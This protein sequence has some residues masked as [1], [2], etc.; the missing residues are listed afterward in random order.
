MKRIAIFSII[1]NT[2][3]LLVSCS[4]QRN[5]TLTYIKYGDYKVVIR[6]LELINSGIHNIDI[7][8]ADIQDD[9]FPATE[10]FQCFLR[11]YDFVGLEATWR[12]A[13]VIDIHFD[14]GVVSSFSNGAVISAKRKIPD[15]FHVF[16]HDANNCK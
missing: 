16:I 11:G 2:L 13:T 8:V 3:L 9:H 14:C 1:V 7:C 10:G 12:S 6:D 5:Q 15:A 4:T